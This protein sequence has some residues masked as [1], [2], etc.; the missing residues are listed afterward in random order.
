MASQLPFSLDKLQLGVIE[1]YR[2][3][4]LRF[5]VIGILAGKASILNAHY[6]IEDA[7]AAFNKDSLNF[8]SVYVVDICPIA[9]I[10]PSQQRYERG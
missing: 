2:R 1:F 6:K 8:D 10:S 5:I 3:N 9:A 7:N 4:D